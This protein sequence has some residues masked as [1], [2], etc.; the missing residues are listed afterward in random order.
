MRLIGLLVLLIGFSAG[1]LNAA[2]IRL[3]NASYNSAL[4]LFAAITGNTYVGDFT[5]EKKI[6]YFICKNINLEKSNC[7]TTY[8]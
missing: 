3:E 4:S 8:L 7:L 2:G 5:T 1:L 6:T